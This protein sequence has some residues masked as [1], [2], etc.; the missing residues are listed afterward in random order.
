MSAISGTDFGRFLQAQNA[1]RPCE[2][3]GGTQFSAWDET[4]QNSRTMIMAP[5]FPGFDIMGADALEIA[6]TSCKNCGAVRLFNRKTIA[7]WLAAN[8]KP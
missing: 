4:S 7:E 1:T 3:C 2:A 8:P 5:K 6:L